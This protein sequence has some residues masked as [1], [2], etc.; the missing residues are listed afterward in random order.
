MDNFFAWLK[1]KNITTHTVAV[2]VL[3][4]ATVIS[5]DQQVRDWVLELF[6]AHPVIGT[7]LVAL[8]GIILKY[9]HSSSAAG[10]MVQA[11]AIQ[12]KPDAPTAS[13]IDA[14]TPSK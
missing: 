14:A 10:T 12:D 6:K 2:A 8:A 7:N 9:S 11:R 3:A 13:Q 1:S 4:V 5:T